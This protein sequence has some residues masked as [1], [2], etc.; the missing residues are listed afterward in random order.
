MG[1][2]TR[3]CTVQDNEGGE[4]LFV[5]VE[6]PRI[7]TDFPVMD[8]RTATKDKLTKGIDHWKLLD[9]PPTT[10]L[11]YDIDPVLGSPLDDTT[12]LP[13]ENRQHFLP[14]PREP[15]IPRRKAVKNGKE[16]INGQHHSP[17][18]HALPGQTKYV[19]VC[20]EKWKTQP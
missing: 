17:T 5:G 3:A 7:S 9:P 8:L 14:V 15:Q 16:T 10:G 18:I 12:L 2:D 13:E 1:K 20:A 19:E 11:H 4:D 6:A